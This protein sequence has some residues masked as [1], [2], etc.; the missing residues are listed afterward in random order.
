MSSPSRPP[1]TPDPRRASVAEASPSR[2]AAVAAAGQ[3]L[4]QALGQGRR[5]LSGEV[6]LARSLARPLTSP[7]KRAL[8]RELAR[9]LYDTTF[10]KSKTPSNGLV[11]LLT[12]KSQISLIK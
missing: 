1:S 2:H 11:H 5:R 9:P 6:Q 12:R 4:V 3:L 7:H 10:A 8:T